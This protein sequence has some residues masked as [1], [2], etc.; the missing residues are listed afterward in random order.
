[1]TNRPVSQ[2]EDLDT[3]FLL[4]TKDFCGYCTAAKNLLKGKELTFTEVNL[5]ENHDLREALVEETGHR[6]VPII[7]DL[8]QGFVFVGGFDELRRAI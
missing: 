1:M 5:Q 3:D 8:R 7:F 2:F 6:T 4:F